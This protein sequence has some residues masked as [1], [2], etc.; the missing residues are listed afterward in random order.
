[1]HFADLAGRY[2]RDP[3]LIQEFMQ[4]GALALLENPELSRVQAAKT[5]RL[6]VMKRLRD[7]GEAPYYGAPYIP[8]TLGQMME[9]A[10]TDEDATLAHDMRVNG[11]PVR[12]SYADLMALTGFTKGTLQAKK[13]RRQP[14][15]ILVVIDW[16]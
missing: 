6:K 16:A 12:L 2:F 11:T 1:M 9:A 13:T 10:P 8:V 4:E 15:T 5:A 3:V 14:M 7:K